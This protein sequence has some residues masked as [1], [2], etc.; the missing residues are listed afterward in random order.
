[1]ARY[2]NPALSVDGV[3]LR[4]GSVLL[5]RRRRPPFR[6]RLALPGGF[7][8]YEETVETAVS[9][10]I[11]E[12]TGLHARPW[13]IL[14]VYSGPDRDP[15]HPTTTVVFALRGRA[16]P[17]RAGDDAAEARWVPLR[18]ARSLAFDHD[19]ILGES[20]RRLRSGRYVR[21]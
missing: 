20:L 13:A 1:M 21:L 10:E 17:P 19:R 6:G 2:R 8:E 7:V 16:G 9:R 4:D 5:V 14:G 15:R 11:L 18:E 12:E 3:W